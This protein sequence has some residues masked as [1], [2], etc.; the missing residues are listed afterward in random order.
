MNSIRDVN[1]VNT[2]KGKKYRHN[3]DKKAPKNYKNLGNERRTVTAGAGK[4]GPPTTSKATC[5]AC[6]KSNHQFKECRYKEFVCNLCK[7]KGHLAKVCKSRKSNYKV[8]SNNYVSSE[9][10]QELSMDFVNMFNLSKINF[11][12]PFIIKMLV[13]GVPLEMELD[14]GAGVSVLPEGILKNKLTD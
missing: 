5:F 8:K 7:T 2:Y 6:G 10:T 12:K 13:N 9:E 11:C 3:E 1:V 14:T 4:Q